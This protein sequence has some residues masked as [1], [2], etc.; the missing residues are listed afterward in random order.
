MNQFIPQNNEDTLASF[1]EREKPIS[2]KECSQLRECNQLLECDQLCESSSPHEAWLDSS[3]LP[4]EN[5]NRA[6]WE[7]E[8][9]AE[10][11]LQSQLVDAIG[12][13]GVT[14]P[15]SN[16]TLEQV[17][18]A[19]QLSPTSHLRVTLNSGSPEDVAFL[20]ETPIADGSLTQVSVTSNFAQPENFLA[21]EE[22]DMLGSLIAPMPT[23]NKKNKRL[24]TIS[25]A[26]SIAAMMPLFWGARNEFASSPGQA[27]NEDDSNDLCTNREPQTTSSA[28]TGPRIIP[29]RDRLTSSLK[30]LLGLPTPGARKPSKNLGVAAQTV[31]DWKS[32]L[33]TSFDYCLG[34]SSRFQLEVPSWN[35]SNAENSTTRNKNSTLSQ[36]ESWHRKSRMFFSSLRMSSAKPVDTVLDKS[37]SSFNALTSFNTAPAKMSTESFS[38]NTPSLS[39]GSPS[40]SFEESITTDDSRAWLSVSRNTTGQTAKPSK[41]SRVRNFLRALTIR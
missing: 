36:I 9:V 37:T 34:N 29:K 33:D 16:L 5:R 38:W 6:P 35:P 26:S 10:F 22:V 15:A 25:V 17:P 8:I 27:W 20:G 11:A 30:D 21:S 13:L 4:V 14:A 2:L 40:E 28:K 31:A 24:S 23:S 7:E 18:E 19:V 32:S 1:L 3:E 39:M 41:R 12:E